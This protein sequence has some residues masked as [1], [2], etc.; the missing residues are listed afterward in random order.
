MHEKISLGNNVLVNGCTC[1]LRPN[2]SKDFG[3]ISCFY[4]W[5]FPTI[6]GNRFLFYTFITIYMYLF[7]RFALGFVIPPFS[8]KD[9]T[10]TI[11]LWPLLFSIS[12]QTLSYRRKITNHPL[13]IGFPH[14]LISMQDVVHNYVAFKCSLIAVITLSLCTGELVSLT[15][16]KDTE[17]NEQFTS[18]N[19]LNKLN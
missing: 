12:I 17:L 9:L 14:Q 16:Y 4:T 18:D 11:S 19:Y 13:L 10:F 2:L 1:Y 6:L 15:I 5:N 8:L 7:I 3:S